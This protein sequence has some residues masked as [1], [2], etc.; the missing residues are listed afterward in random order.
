MAHEAISRWP[1]R[2]KKQ[3]PL[4][5][6]RYLNNRIHLCYEPGKTFSFLISKFI[7]VLTNDRDMDYST[8]SV[9]RGLEFLQ[10]INFCLLT[11]V[12]DSTVADCKEFPRIFV[13]KND[14]LRPGAF[15]IT[16]MGDVDEPKK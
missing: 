12:I 10:F 11:W 8:F 4:Q 2:L 3:L 13:F 14:P 15:F 1:A 9:H 16:V 7:E 5:R 6:L